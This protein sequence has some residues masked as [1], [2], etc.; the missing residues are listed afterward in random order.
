M[1][2][3]E[4]RQDRGGLLA[5]PVR[6]VFAKDDAWTVTGDLFRRDRDGDFWIVDHISGVIRTAA[7][8][9][10]SFPIEEAL[11]TLDAIDLAA[12]YGVPGRRGER[13]V[14]AVTLR[15]GRTIDGDDLA[16]AL[17]SLDERSRP[18]VV[19]VIDE[20]PL[21]TWYR[22]LKTPLRAAGVPNTGV[23]FLWKKKHATYVRRAPSPKER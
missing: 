2:L 9:V 14:A 10:P 6:G 5:A 7:G 19:R 22:P 8:A 16:A 21:T 15:P 12:A 4:A 23:A 11:A 20:M 3:A 13:I 1:L 17:A 18:T